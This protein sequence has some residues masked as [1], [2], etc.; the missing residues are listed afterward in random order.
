MSYIVYGNRRSGSALIELALDVIKAPYEIRNVDLDADDQRGSGYASVNPARKLPTLITP[1][2]E[3]LTESLC[4]LV[5]LDE[6]HR[7]ANLLPP[8]AS[9]ARAQALRW[10]CFVATELYPLVEINDYPQRFSPDDET[11]PGI[12]NRAREMW[13]DRLKVIEQNIEGDPWLLTDGFS[14]ADIY[15]AV[16]SRWAQQDDWR[17]SNIGR[18]ER[19]AAAIA[20]REETADTWARH[21]TPTR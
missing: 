3:R 1:Q 18:V 19:I 17:P 7:S 5:S 13:R 6:R 10:M 14:L 9:A 20:R 8:P 12:R 2:G 16:V 15:I 11:A 4:I 21:F